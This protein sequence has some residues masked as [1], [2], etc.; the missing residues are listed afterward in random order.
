M[1][2]RTTLYGAAALALATLCTPDALRSALAGAS[3]ALFEATPFLFAGALLE[4][5]LRRRCALL[6]HLGCG[7]GSGPSARSLPA[8]AATWIA[9]GPLVAVE[10][11]LAALLV[12][13][14]LHRVSPRKKTHRSLAH[15]LSELAA[16]FPAA[17]LAGV[18]MQFASTFDSRSLPQAAAAFFGAALGFVAS[19]CGLGA[20]ALAGALRVHAPVAAAAFLCVAGLV[21][22]R[23]LAGGRHIEPGD[24]ALAYAMLAFALGIVAW[25]HGDALVHPA[26]AA[27]LAGCACAALV[28][29]Y[30]H[31]RSRRAAG[32]A[33][34]ALM[35]AGAI[36]GAPPPQYHATETTLTDLFAGER[37]TFTGA[38][39]RDGSSSA[40][41]RYAI[42]CCRA[43]AAPVAVRLDRSP[44]Y[45]N[46]TWLRVE[47]RVAQNAG[48]FR[49]VTEHAE[50]VAPPAD[51]FLYR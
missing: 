21:D 42:T 6:E 9:F 12:A 2:V 29:A 17:L 27:A 23:A 26:F 14:I 35:L 20:V 18:A 30:A 50:R 16:V 40:V 43:D 41:V 34:P 15:P 51:P 10:R 1:S 31:R 37:L 48:A 47:G 36:L 3:S 38:L 11:Y 7:C 22:L 4:L 13:Q 33:A 24:D 44:P 39:D 49:L 46:G 25:R 19:P 45:P 28:C 32:R 5:L 8:A